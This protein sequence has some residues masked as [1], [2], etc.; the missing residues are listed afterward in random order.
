MPSADDFPPPP[1]A[2][3]SDDAI[4]LRLLRVMGPHN[5]DARPAN[6]QF[7]SAVPEYR[8]AIHRRSDGLRVGRIHIRATNDRRIVHS[9]GHSGYAVEEAH[10]RNGYATRA[11]RLIVGLAR[12]WGISPF[13]VLV[14]PDN[15]ASRRALEQ[16]GLMLVDTIDSSNEIMALGTGPK[17]CRYSTDIKK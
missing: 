6:E 9:I 12:H 5:A 10:R 11:I 1:P 14:E 16:A 8:F 3:L 7:L 13:W 4:E 15:I 17:M 2:L